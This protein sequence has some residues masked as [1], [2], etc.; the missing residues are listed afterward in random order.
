MYKK[1]YSQSI[2][3][4]SNDVM[5][6]EEISKIIDRNRLTLATKLIKHELTHMQPD[7]LQFHL[8]LDC[9]RFPAL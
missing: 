6:K 3:D 4:Q 8:N 1:T 5:K 2:I 7:A 9:H